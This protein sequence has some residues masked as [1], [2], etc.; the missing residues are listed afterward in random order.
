MSLDVLRRFEDAWL[1]GQRPVL[2]AFVPS[3]TPM[4][5]P[6]A[7][8][9]LLHELIKL[10]LEYRWRS[11]GSDAGKGP[12]LE[13]YL[14]SYPELGQPDQPPL[15]LVTWEY[16]IRR[17]YGD[18]PAAA[19]Y[20]A[21][22]ARCGP[23]LLEA[24][25]RTD[26][27]R[28]AEFSPD[29]GHPAAGNDRIAAV[30]R[31]GSGTIASTAMLVEALQKLELFSGAQ[32]TELTGD[33]QQRFPQPRELA[34]ELLQ[35]N[36]LTP[37]QVN[38][39]LRGAGAELLLGPYLV[40]E[41]LGE[42]GMGQVFKARHRRMGRVVALKLLRH[43]LLADA[44]AVSR[45]YREIRIVSKLTHPNIVHAYD[46]G[47][48]GTA[49]ALVM[50]YVEGIDLSRRVKQSGPLPVDQ[51][52]ACIRQSALGLQH[53][54]EQGLIHRDVKPSNLMLVQATGVVKI[55]DLGLA[56]LHRGASPQLVADVPDDR[57]TGSLTPVGGVL[58][59]GTPDYLAPEQALDFHAAD[60]RAD[61][62]S[63]GCTFFFLLTG[64]PPFP[65]GTLAQKL[66]WHQHAEPPSIESL[67]PDVPPQLTVVLRRLLAK[68]P[69]DRFQT[70]GEVATAVGNPAYQRLQQPP[71][72]VS[73]VPVPTLSGNTKVAGTQPS[74]PRAYERLRRSVL[75]L[76][77]AL[78]LLL[79]FAMP[80][81][82]PPA[83]TPTPTQPQLVAKLPE[84][85]LLP[86]P[87][88]VDAEE[89]WNALLAKANLP[90]VDPEGVRRD[91]LRLRGRHP[92]TPEAIRAAEMLMKLPSPLDH[93]DAARIPP[94]EQQPHLKELVAVLGE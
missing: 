58:M 45:F 68:R 25:R 84:P 81:P 86:P 88:V 4:A 12:R 56:R 28:E 79:Y 62:Y 53:A 93:L 40:L 60:I 36:W 5:N 69:D 26:A 14:A 10:D 18:R 33:L 22:F 54:H 83:P 75:F 70:P 3:P 30:P 11:G 71:P 16:F 24:L 47:P 21:R 74:P 39:L 37:Y 76:V 92:G 29:Q 38:Q 89:A 27:E 2:S 7:R 48:I 42:G 1:S 85:E 64:Q 15:D 32:V 57:S 73:P 17:R 44:D 6:S 90:Q 35:R 46:A 31:A 55:L 94:T 52:C 23:P 8:R 63:L 91:V 67:R 82:D 87:R 77:A 41:R 59:M 13:E 51:A 72:S 49:H 61:I 65:G 50:E 34:R 19:E 80:K 9:E 78:A 43:E 20:A 66:L